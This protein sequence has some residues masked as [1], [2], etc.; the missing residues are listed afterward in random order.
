MAKI[1][2]HKNNRYIPGEHLLVCERT[3]RVIYASDARKEWNGR[4]VHKDWWEPKHPALIFTQV[5]TDDSRAK[6]YVRPEPND[7][8][9]IIP[10]AC[11]YVEDG[12]F[13]PSIDPLKLDLYVNEDC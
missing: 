4:V 12:Y 9:K 5:G 7:V 10:N 1:P 11:L 6:G 8:F 13:E 2:D 3:G